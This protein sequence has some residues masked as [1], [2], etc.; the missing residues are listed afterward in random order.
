V[1]SY[2]NSVAIVR[3][4]LVSRYF[5]AL[6]VND[7]AR[8]IARH[9]L[10]LD[11]A[12]DYQDID[13]LLSVTD[14][15]STLKRRHHVVEETWNLLRLMHAQYPELAVV[16]AWM[17]LAPGDAQSQCVVAVIPQSDETFVEYSARNELCCMFIMSRGTVHVNLLFEA[18]GADA[19]VV[20]VNLG[21]DALGTEAMDV[22][23]RYAVTWEGD[24]SWVIARDA[25]A[26]DDGSFVMPDDDAEQTHFMVRGVVKVASSG[27]FPL[28]VVT[29]GNIT[30][31]RCC[32]RARVEARSKCILTTCGWHSAQLR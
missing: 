13:F 14:S 8:F 11:V 5:S 1:A 9:D 16:Q 30:T 12:L 23:N 7:V 27:A 32:A 3:M 31:V 21:A 22:S 24:S 19:R 18:L 28:T 29:R 6:F 4:R 26:L 20:S 2:L 15:F 17:S 10:K 25:K